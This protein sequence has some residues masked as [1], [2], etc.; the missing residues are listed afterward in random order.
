M[1]ITRAALTALGVLWLAGCATAREQAEVEAFSELPAPTPHAT[2]PTDE[3]PEEEGAVEPEEPIE[4]LDD[5]LHLAALHSPELRAAYHEAEAAARSIP[6]ARKLPEPTVSYTFFLRSVETRV[7]PQNHKLGVS[8]ALPWPTKL[9]A[10][11]DVVAERVRVRRRRFEAVRTRLYRDIRKPWARLAFVE[12]ARGIVRDEIDVLE[13]IEQSV[14]AQLEVGRATYEDLTRVSLRLAELREDEAALRDRAEALRARVRSVV[15]LEPD[16]ALPDARYEEIPADVPPAP[17]LREALGDNPELRVA[18]AEIEAAEARVAEAET[19]RL[20]DLSFGLDW[21][22]VGEAEMQDVGDSGKDA[23]MVMAGVRIPLWTSAY[24]AEEDAARARG[25][26]ADARRE[27]VLRSSEAQLDRILSELT[28]ARR[29]VA[30]YEDELVPGARSALD[31]ALT[32]YA[33]ARASFLDL[34]DLEQQVL[35][36]RLALSKARADRI[37]L[38]AELDRLLGREVI[39]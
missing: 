1:N 31:A 7:G 14:R 26:A 5:L 6:A 13:N 25:R 8:Q 3:A 2:A 32:S 23:V 36:Y 11:A 34:M 29:T 21:V 15:G 12:H 24:D 10:A 37:A 30:L 22:A 16:V 33:A 20:P 38:R 39:E 9:S 35:R 4:D 28:T 17:E 27:E 18:L 19:T